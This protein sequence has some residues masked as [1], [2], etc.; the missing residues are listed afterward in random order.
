MHRLGA[1]VVLLAS[2]GGDDGGGISPEDPLSELDGDGVTELC[3]RLVDTYEKEVDFTGVCTFTM[4]LFSQAQLAQKAEPLDPQ[5]CRI[6]VLLCA[7]ELEDQTLDPKMCAERLDGEL[8][9]CKAT[10]GEL[11]ECVGFTLNATG[12][13][14]DALSCDA[15]GDPEALDT[16]LADVEAS[17][18]EV[19]A[20][21]VALLEC[22]D[23]SLLE[24]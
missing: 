4:L 5:E 15:A 6:A 1:L 14:L 13:A 20:G 11:E 2:C 12:T 21:C 18:D 10:V 19:P 24:I 17:I 3:T 22:S 7:N 8:D 9:D 23:L 16:L